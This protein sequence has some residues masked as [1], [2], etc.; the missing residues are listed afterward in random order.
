MFNYLKHIITISLITIYIC[1]KNPLVIIPNIDVQPRH[2]M[3]FQWPLQL[4]TNFCDKVVTIVVVF[5]TNQ[6]THNVLL[7][8]FSISIFFCGRNVAYHGQKNHGPTYSTKS[9]I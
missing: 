4:H 9:Y 8:W 2:H 3:T 5:L 1:P 6:K 7:C